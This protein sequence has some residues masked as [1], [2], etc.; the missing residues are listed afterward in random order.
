MFQRQGSFDKLS[1]KSY[2]GG[3]KRLQIKAAGDKG[4]DLARYAFWLVARVPIRLHV[5]K[6][7][8]HV[9]D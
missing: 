7:K 4:A 6:I 8:V 2:S 5:W 9:Y 1:E 3:G